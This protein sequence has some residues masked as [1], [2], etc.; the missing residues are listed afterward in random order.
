MVVDVVAI[1]MTQL[2]SLDRETA[3]VTLTLT[4]RCESVT[5]STMAD[6]GHVPSIV[7]DSSAIE[8]QKDDAIVDGVRLIELVRDWSTQDVEKG[9]TSVIAVRSAFGPREASRY[10]SA[11][12]R[13]HDCCNP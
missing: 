6:R 10:R 8:P 2:L 11:A 9:L 1:A 7:H 4:L 12:D 3:E 13:G 5:L